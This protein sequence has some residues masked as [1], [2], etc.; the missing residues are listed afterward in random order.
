MLLRTLKLRQCSSRGH[1]L[2]LH[3]HL[4]HQL[5]WLKLRLSSRRLLLLL[6]NGCL[7]KESL[8]RLRGLW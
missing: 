5:L 1:R 4:L 7:L 6:L 3:L 2:H 8:L